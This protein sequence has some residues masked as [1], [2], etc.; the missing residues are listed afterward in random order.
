MREPKEKYDFLAVG[1]AIKAA[2]ESKGWTREQVAEML[3]LAPRYIM[4]IE[5]T[6]QHPSL[7]VF[8]ELV[9]LFNIS[10][11]QYIFP[12][13]PAERSTRRRQLDSLLDTLDDKNL[14]VV[15]ATA[16][17]IVKAKTAEEA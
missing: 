15:E 10:V 6:G 5:N 2:R 1:Q 13:K 7:Q 11:D 8:Y 17:G 3:D 14:I 9:R 4:S 12:D 16:K